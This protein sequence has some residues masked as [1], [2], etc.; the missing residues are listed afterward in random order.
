MMRRTFIC[1]FDRGDDETVHPFE[2]HVQPESEYEWQA[3]GFVSSLQTEADAPTKTSVTK[4]LVAN[5]LPKVPTGIYHN[6][7]N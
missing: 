3:S 7:G 2:V 4:M 1:D 6:F 5:I